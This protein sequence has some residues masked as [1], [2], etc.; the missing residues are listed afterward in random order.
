M[1]EAR[2]AVVP[3]EVDVRPAVRA[4]ITTLGAMTAARGLS[5]LWDDL[6]A[7]AGTRWLQAGLAAVTVFS[8]W[9]IAQGAEIM[10]EL[11]ALWSLG[12]P[13]MPQI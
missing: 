2:K 4:E 3:P 6:L 1:D 10:R 9:S 11:D 13:L 7:L 8:G 5:S 12:G